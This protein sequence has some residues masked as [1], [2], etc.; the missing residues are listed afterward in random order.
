MEIWLCVKDVDLVFRDVGYGKIKE[1][2][3]DMD[4][5]EVDNHED[6]FMCILLK[7]KCKLK[8]K[9]KFSMLENSIGIY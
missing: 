6:K 8:F 5:R 7:L 3:I 2:P 4:S 1:S 9:L